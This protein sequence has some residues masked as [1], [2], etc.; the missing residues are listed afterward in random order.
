MT[1]FIQGYC[2]QSLLRRGNTKS[3]LN[4]KHL[5]RKL[6]PGSEQQFR[7]LAGRLEN[8]HPA[9]VLFYSEMAGA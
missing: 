2:V 1:R 6:V 7:G 9:T 8:S 3:S 5:I 4:I